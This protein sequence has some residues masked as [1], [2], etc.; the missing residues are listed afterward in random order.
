M[1]LNLYADDIHPVGEPAVLATGLP[2][3]R[4]L[5]AHTLRVSDAGD[6]MGMA[7]SLNNI[8][9]NYRKMDDYEKA[10][11]FYL[12]SLELKEKLTESGR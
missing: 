10:L 3:N 6:S 5:K 11:D 9:V 4:R 12:R 8:G 1:V 2:G 7:N